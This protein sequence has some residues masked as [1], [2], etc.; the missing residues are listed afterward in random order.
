MSALIGLASR[1]GLSE[2]SPVPLFS[3]VLSD[4]M[5]KLI[6]IDD[7]NIH[8]RFDQRLLPRRSK[9]K[10]EII[11]IS[12]ALEQKILHGKIKVRRSQA[13]YPD[14]RY[15]FESDKKSHDLPLMSASSMVSELAP[16]FPCLFVTMSTKGDLLI[17]EEPEAHLHPAAQRVI[18]NILVQLANAGVT[19]LI[20]THSDNVIEQIGN[21]VIASNAE[22]KINGQALEEKNISAYLFNRPKRNPHKATSVKKILFDPEYGILTE[23][24]L[25]VSS[26]LYNETVGLLNGMEKNND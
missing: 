17:I 8:R 24:H 5:Q 25:D 4:F 20:T 14:F 21:Y 15:V 2:T 3:G 18:T 10:K 9:T 23:D 16:V 22:K 19:V 7:K 12:D 11:E 1:A 13:D 26:S 6:A